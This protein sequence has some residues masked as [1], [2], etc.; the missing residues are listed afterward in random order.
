M[1]TRRWGFG[2][3]GICPSNVNKAELLRRHVSVL[4]ECPCSE[5]GHGAVKGWYGEFPRTVTVSERNWEKNDLGKSRLM[6]RLP[7]HC[8]K[9]HSW[10]LLARLWLGAGSWELGAGRGET[11]EL[12]ALKRKA[13]VGGG[14]LDK[15]TNH[16]QPVS[17]IESGLA[18]LG[19][20]DTQ[21]SAVSATLHRRQDVDFHLTPSFNLEFHLFFQSMGLNPTLP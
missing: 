8:S 13:A 16:R 2:G 5:S 3:G 1:V 18:P 4:T 6:A 7:S 10:M 21:R 14:S 20:L 9:K 17:P 19:R 11:E 15:A 12:P